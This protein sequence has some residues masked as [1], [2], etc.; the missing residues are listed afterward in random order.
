MNIWESAGSGPG[1]SD[2]SSQ[3]FSPDNSLREFAED[4]KQIAFPGRPELRNPGRSFFSASYSQN[5][6]LNFID[7]P[8]PTRI[9]RL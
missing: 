6:A 4:A 5:D 9:P 3:R 2:T 1:I 8:V 7:L